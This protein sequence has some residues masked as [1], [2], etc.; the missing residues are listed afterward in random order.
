MK[1]FLS[2]IELFPEMRG[3]TSTS[4]PTMDR[5]PGNHDSL[6]VLNSVWIVARQHVDRDDL[7]GLRA[8]HPG[9]VVRLVH[10][11]VPGAAFTAIVPSMSPVVAS[12]MATALAC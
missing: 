8:R 3:A 1:S 5:N 10:H 12:W 4:L 2:T 6:N 9:T 11:D 7:V